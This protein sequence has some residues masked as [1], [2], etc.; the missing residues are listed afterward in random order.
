M[1]PM[2]EHFKW[3]YDGKGGIISVY[4]SGCWL[5]IKLVSGSAPPVEILAELVNDWVPVVNEIAY[6]NNL[7]RQNPYAIKI[8]EGTSLCLDYSLIECRD[9]EM[10]IFPK[11]GEIHISMYGR[12]NEGLAMW[13]WDFAILMDEIKFDCDIIRYIN[14][15]P[16]RIDTPESWRHPQD[17]IHKGGGNG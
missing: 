7:N 10:K 16:A 9:E 5:E 4:L 14:I 1:E 11:K 6:V 2:V 3:E 12:L 13:P 15:S 17:A 8:R